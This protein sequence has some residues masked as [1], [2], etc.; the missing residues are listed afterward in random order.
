M[1]R[2]LAIALQYD[3]SEKALPL[4]VKLADKYNGE[5]RWYLEA[6]GIATTGREKAVMEAWEKGHQNKDPKNNE[7]IVWRLKMEPVQLGGPTTQPATK[8]GHASAQGVAGPFADDNGVAAHDASN[9]V[10][11]LPAVVASKAAYQGVSGSFP[12]F[13]LN[14]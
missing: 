13:F 2:E 3:Q 8:E 6:F 4:I 14:K 11:L 10:E 5:D 12:R 9:G 1:W 7:G